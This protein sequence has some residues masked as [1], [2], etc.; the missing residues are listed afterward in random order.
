MHVPVP[1]QGSTV[2]F[3]REEFRVT[4][5]E[6]SVWPIEFKTLRKYTY[7]IVQLLDVIRIAPS[8]I[9]LTV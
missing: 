2:S 7:I 9:Y 8:L 5:Y 1:G 4:R 6:R 3:G